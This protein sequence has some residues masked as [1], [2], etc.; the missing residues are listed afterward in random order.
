MK[1]ISV[2]FRLTKNLMLWSFLYLLIRKLG[3]TW[4]RNQI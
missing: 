4:S 2:D 1:K 3:F